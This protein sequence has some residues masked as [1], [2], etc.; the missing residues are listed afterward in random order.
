MVMGDI[1]TRGCNFCAVKKGKPGM[2]DKDEPRKLA[3]SLKEMN[4]FD[5]VVI[6][7]VDRDD[8]EDQGSMHF[9]ECIR[10][11]KKEIPHIKIEVLIPDFQGRD[12]LLNNVL[13]AKPDVLAH[14]IET[15][16]RLQTIRDRR[17]NYLQ[18]LQVLSS[19]KRICPKAYTKSSL[20]LGLGEKD[21]EVLQAMSDLR[22]RDVDIITF[23]QYLKPKNRVLD[24]HE[25]VHPEK[26][27]YFEEQA[28][29]IGFKYCISGPFVRS[30]YKAEEFLRVIA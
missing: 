19:A 15:V 25:Y 5:Y 12:D 18:S 23:G 26:F 17:A 29:N 7:S 21:N 24:M 8:L 11:I 1:C 13:D 30:S 28:Y 27:K 4:V 3:K 22:K 16:E 2:L 10:E 9:A 14:N 20:M 6:T